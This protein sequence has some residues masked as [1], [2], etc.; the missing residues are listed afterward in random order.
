MPPSWTQLQPL[1]SLPA[2]DDVGDLRAYFGSVIGLSSTQPAE[3]PGPLSVEAAR[4][5]LALLPP[6]AAVADVAPSLL[7][8]W[9]A[10]RVLELL[11]A[12]DSPTTA[13]RALQLFDWLHRLAPEAPHAQ[14]CTGDTLCLMIGLYGGWRKPKAVRCWAVGQAGAAA[15]EGA[16][17]AGKRADRPPRGNGPALTPP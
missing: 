2:T 17:R 13:Q 1:P 4:R 6:G 11:Q 14:L 10:A 3:P 7:E 12:L 8:G 15:R 9:D 5:K 16:L